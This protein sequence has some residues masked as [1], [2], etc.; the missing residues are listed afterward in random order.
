MCNMIEVKRSELIA[1]LEAALAALKSKD[2]EEV[3]PEDVEALG[4]H[5]N[6]RIKDVSGGC[7][8]RGRTTGELAFHP[9]W[10]VCD[11]YVAKMEPKMTPGELKDYIRY[12]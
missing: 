5:L 9:E 8:P 6:W 3:F 1:N 12:R 11:G 2:C 7:H 10:Y 4:A